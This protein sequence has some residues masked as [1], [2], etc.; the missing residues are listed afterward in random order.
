[1]PENARLIPKKQ[2]VVGRETN[3][4]RERMQWLQMRTCSSSFQIFFLSLFSHCWNKRENFLCQPRKKCN[5]FPFPLFHLLKKKESSSFECRKRHRNVWGENRRP[6]QST[7][8]PFCFSSFSEKTKLLLWNAR[9]SQMKGPPLLLAASLVSP[10]LVL[11]PE[12][13][14]SSWE[15]FNFGV[16]EEEGNENKMV[17]S[18]F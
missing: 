4:G 11:Q 18:F 17:L 8:P 5:C 7:L 15:G 3:E 13:Y 2:R 6:C 14:F 1:M 12:K 10:P 16:E 9:E